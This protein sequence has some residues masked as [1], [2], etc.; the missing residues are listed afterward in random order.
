RSRLMPRLKFL[1]IC[2]GELLL[3]PSLDAAE[4]APSAKSP[5]AARE[6]TLELP[7]G[8]L[9]SVELVDPLSSGKSKSGSAFR[10]RV[11]EGVYVRGALA[12]PPGSTVRGTVVEARPS[13]RLGGRSKLELTLSTLD[14]DGSSYSLRTDTLSYAGEGHAGSNFGSLFGGA[15]QGA[16][17]GVLFGGEKGAVIG[18]GAGAAAGGASKVLSGKQDVEFPQGAK[19]MF[20]VTAPARLPAPPPQPAAKETGEGKPPSPPAEKPVEKPEPKPE[21]KAAQPAT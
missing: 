7:S 6:E 14:L 15:L 1:N 13:D 4:A 3:T 10:A 21:E 5:L 12:L 11:T 2:F 16:L 18:A 17:Y 20:E 8:T 19:L 9:L